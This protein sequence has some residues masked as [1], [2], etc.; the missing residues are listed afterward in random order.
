M[1]SMQKSTKKQN[2]RKDGSPKGKKSSSSN[3]SHK[4]SSSSRNKEI[5]ILCQTDSSSSRRDKDSCL[6]GCEGGQQEPLHAGS[7]SAGG[8]DIPSNSAAPMGYYQEE[9]K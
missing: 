4:R 7:G 2:G 8:D 1:A 3:R 5:D 6:D 9:G